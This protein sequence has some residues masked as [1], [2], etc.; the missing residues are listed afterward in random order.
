MWPELQFYA[1]SLQLH[2]MHSH[3]GFIKRV[4]MCMFVFSYWFFLSLL[5]TFPISWPKFGPS[6]PSGLPLSSR[7]IY[8]TTVLMCD[9]RLSQWG[10]LCGWLVKH[11]CHTHHRLFESVMHALQVHVA[12]GQ[13]DE[14]SLSLKTLFFSF[15]FCAVLLYFQMQFSWSVSSFLQD[16]LV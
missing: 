15:F 14:T 4:W 3:L 9:L 8:K 11:T 6:P 10:L 2:I 16:V 5:W 1:R 12:S 13:S 7:V